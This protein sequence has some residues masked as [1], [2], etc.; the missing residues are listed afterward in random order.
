[1]ISSNQHKNVSSL[2]FENEASILRAS[3]KRYT[4]KIKASFL[5]SFMFNFT[6]SIKF[7]PNIS[8]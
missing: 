1:M 3:P 2:S 7:L 4:E 6:P 8:T 5:P